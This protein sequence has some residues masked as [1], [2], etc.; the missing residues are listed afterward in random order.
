MLCV[1]RYIFINI[2]FFLKLYL[3]ANTVTMR[4]PTTTTTRSRSINEEGQTNK[5]HCI[6]ERKLFV[7]MITAFLLF[8]YA[9][10]IKDI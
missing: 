9:W 6:N 7:A 3:Q 8:G 1:K 4:T 10:M 5:G 2:Y